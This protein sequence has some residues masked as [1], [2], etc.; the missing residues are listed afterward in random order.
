[1]QGTATDASAPRGGSRTLALLK[2]GVVRAGRL[3]EL[4][5]ALAVDFEL[6]ALRMIRLRPATVAALYVE[7]VD[8]P[9]FADVVAHLTSGPCVAVVC[10][11]AEG[12]APQ[13]LTRL[14]GFVDPRRAA[15]ETLRA[16]FGETTERNAIH[17][18]E[19][20]ADAAREIALL[21]GDD[22]LPSV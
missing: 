13:R 2:P 16:R 11:H 21:F 6:S 19:S 9:W 5:A 10:V 7:H 3:P 8:Q 1:M 12:D 14:V 4:L 22:P 20:S 15:P 18:S 17:S